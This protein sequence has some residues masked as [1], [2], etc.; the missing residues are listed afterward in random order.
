VPAGTPSFRFQQEQARRRRS[1]RDCEELRGWSIS[2]ESS[3]THASSERAEALGG[4][5]GHG[6]RSRVL[7]ERRS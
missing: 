1:A 7:L 6:A 2:A 4:T 3:T 5:Q